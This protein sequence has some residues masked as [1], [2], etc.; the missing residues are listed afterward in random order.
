MNDL[1]ILDILLEE[2]V[3]DD[4]KYSELKTLND[5][6]QKYI[7][8]ILEDENIIKE[9][10]LIRL[11]SRRINIPY[12]NL[13]VSLIDR[14]IVNLIPEEIIRTNNVIPIFKIQN[15]LTVGMVD[16]TDLYLIDE[17]KQI[18]GLNIS[19]VLVSQSKLRG[20]I[21]QLFGIEDSMTE[22][23]NAL[24][25]EITA[26]FEEEEY[27]DL[28]TTAE[29][30]PIIKLVNLIIE[31][32][33]VDRASDIHIEPQHN[34]LRIRYRIDGQLYEI[35][36][37]PRQFTSSIISRIKVLAR[38]DISEKRIPQD[39][40]IKLKV[41]ERDIDIRVSTSPT[42]FGEKIVMRLFDKTQMLSSLENLGLNEEAYNRVI[43]LLKKNTGILLVTG[44][45]GSGKTTTLYAAIQQLDSIKKNIVTI[46]DPV[47]YQLNNISQIEVNPRVG[48]TFATGLRSI[49]R[50]DPDIM[51]VGEIRDI[52]TAE[53]AI[54]SALTGHFVLSTLHTNN[55]PDSLT[56][57]INMGIEP[58]LIAST[59]QAVI[60]Q[61]LVRM[62]CNDC[63]E[64]F[65]PPREFIKEFEKYAKNEELIFYT[66]RGCKNCKYTGYK[67]RT[68]IFEILEMND[69]IKKLVINKA[70]VENIRQAA[71]NAGMLTLKQD[72]FDK[73]IRGIT[74]LDEALNV[75]HGVE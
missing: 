7:F 66:S 59:L 36:S 65:V 8:E 44:P 23:V 26:E 31:Q 58:Y 69:E 38:L 61:R 42:I 52:E 15:M 60:A 27:I 14:N 63:R 34:R 64:T 68:G 62:L 54:R 20:V 41:N 2:N 25:S 9:E 28:Q 74:S 17:L 46:E 3:I 6:S 12:I 5:R 4:A 49:L 56:R 13:N 53:I 11:I 29:E 50:Q 45:T 48:L 70:S 22:L 24:K 33:I 51:M 1:T 16:P 55:A 35:Q 47:E 37:P 10:E 21:S 19:P 71:L 40:R 39:G 72:A 32:A 75:L 73:I 67:G 57:L 18:T 43:E 30:A